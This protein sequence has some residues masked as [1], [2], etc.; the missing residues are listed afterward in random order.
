MGI[1]WRR[2]RHATFF[3]RCAMQRQ[4]FVPIVQVCLIDRNLCEVPTRML[5]K[6]QRTKL[7][8]RIIEKGKPAMGDSSRTIVMQFGPFRGGVLSQNGQRAR[9]GAS[10]SS[11]RAA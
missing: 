1:E 5:L 6:P 7:L 10:R 4:S 8:P 11:N 9:R 3:L 2:R